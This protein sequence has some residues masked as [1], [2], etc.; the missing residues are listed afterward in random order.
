MKVG[1]IGRTEIL[2]NTAIL[3]K[4]LG[5]SIGCIITAK[6]APEYSR[7]S[8]DF[9]ELANEWQ[10][11][12]ISSARII[13][14]LPL[15][16]QCNLDIGVSINYPGIIPTEVID[17]FPLG[18]LNAH[19]GDLPKYRGNACQAWAILNG[20]SKIGLCIHKMVGGELDSGDII[21][22]DFF[23]IS[24]HTKITQVYEWMGNSV[25][26]LFAEAVAKLRSNPA[27]F[28][29]K[30]SK[31]PKD[32]LRC[33]PLKPEDGRIKWSDSNIQILRTINAFN[34][35]YA[36]AYCTFDRNKLIVWE[37]SLA[38]DENFLAIPGQITLVTETYIEV[39]TGQGKLV[40]HSIEYFG[41]CQPPGKLI[42]SIRQRFS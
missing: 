30:Q 29:E 36:G 42:Q 38:Q 2:Y 4:K 24:T 13:E 6:A 1:I 20:E 35:P 34:K 41:E 25:P 17:A 33:Y 9:M 3:L 40:I 18:I 5:Y 8:K 31:D 7:K 11:P 39:S 10:I 21:V 12:Y 37:A 28:L 27:Y 16:Q 14:Q 23:F 19:G 32:A 26:N 22:R 15:L